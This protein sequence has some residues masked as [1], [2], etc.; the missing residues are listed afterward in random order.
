MGRNLL[1]SSKPQKSHPDRTGGS[2]G[3]QARDIQP[4]NKSGLRHAGC[5]IFDREA[6]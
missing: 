3:L 5:P 4:L 6:G 2:T 1:F